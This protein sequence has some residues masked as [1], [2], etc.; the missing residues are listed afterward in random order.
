MAN[1]LL[2]KIEKAA[3]KG[4]DARVF[5]VLA[6]GQGGAIDLD[7]LD[8]KKNGGLKRKAD[9]ATTYNDLMIEVSSPFDSQF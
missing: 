2:P 7:D 4:E 6:A 5:S 8:L 1:L 9:S 3:E